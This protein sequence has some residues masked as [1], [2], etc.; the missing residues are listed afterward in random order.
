M[1]EERASMLPHVTAWWSEVPAGTPPKRIL[2]DGCLDIIWQ[3]GTVFVAGAGTTGQGSTGPPGGARFVAL[4]FGSGTGPGVLGLPASELV[5][6][7]VP[8][9]SLWPAA[10]VRRL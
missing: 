10:T 8:L 7:Q 6:R 1:Y 3:D 5:D 2:P 4:R 9:D